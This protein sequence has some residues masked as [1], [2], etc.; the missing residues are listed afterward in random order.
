M[1]ICPNGAINVRRLE[2]IGSRVGLRS[3]RTIALEPLVSLARRTSAS[4][5]AARNSTAPSNDGG[6]RSVPKASNNEENQIT[7]APC[8]L[9]SSL[10]CLSEDFM[11]L[12][13]DSP[14]GVL[15]IFHSHLAS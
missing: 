9:G 7:V 6:S 5:E 3:T 14:R 4:T 2:R 10:I 1:T 11:S 12:T 13:A 15:S 8:S